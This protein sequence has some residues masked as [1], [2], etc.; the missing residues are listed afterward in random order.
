MATGRAGADICRET[1]SYRYRLNR[2]VWDI[3]KII[4]ERKI[5]VSLATYIAMII[6]FI[7]KPKDKAIIPTLLA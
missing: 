2:F 5:W 4:T 3:P 6:G 7:K 1:I